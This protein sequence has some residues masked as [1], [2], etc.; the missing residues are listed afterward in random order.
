MHISVKWCSPHGTVQESKAINK[1]TKTVQETMQYIHSHKHSPN[2]IKTR[3]QNLIQ[4]T[5]TY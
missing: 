5:C 4:K 2:K 3:I 1:K